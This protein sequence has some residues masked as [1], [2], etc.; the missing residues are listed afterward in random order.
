MRYDID[1]SREHRVGLDETKNRVEDFAQKLQKDFAVNYHW[2]DDTVR[3]KRTMVEG[4]IDV[5]DSC[6][7]VRVKLGLAFKPMKGEIQKKINRYMDKV[8]T[9]T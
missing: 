9:G 1:I 2:D 7:R 3:F 4:C 8:I 5:E 6:V